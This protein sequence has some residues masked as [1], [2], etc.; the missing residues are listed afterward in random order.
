[1]E[2]LS[3]T[4]RQELIEWL[5]AQLRAWNLREPALVLLSLHEPLAFLGSQALLV[6]QPFVSMLTGTRTAQ[7]LALLL[8]DPQ[9]IARLAARLG[10]NAPNT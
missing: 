6:A 10:D 4:R 8:Q 5:A 9:N 3:E 2:S 1:M 7:D